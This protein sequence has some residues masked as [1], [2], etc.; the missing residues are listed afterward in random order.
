MTYIDLVN[1]VLRRLREDTVTTVN[2]TDYSLMVGDFINDAKR[3]CEDATDWSA[4]RKTLEV[5]TEDG[6]FSYVL[7]G[8]QNRG[9]VLDVVNDTS[10]FFLE[11]RTA[12]E[13][14]RKFLID[15]PEKNSPRYYSFNGVTDDD[16]GDTQVDLFPI[17]DKQYYINFNMII[18]QADLSADTDRLKIPAQ[19]VIHMALAML[20]RERGETGGT[21]TAEYFN[22]AQRYL[23]DAI[24][25]D[26]A[27][28][29]EEMIWYS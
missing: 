7:T 28:H 5:R 24:A 10:N 1:N 4:L 14:N 23:S 17:P 16:E 8:S 29:P 22:I 11:Y 25:F 2:Q 21:S 3:M 15:N 26:A 12:H 9:K 18:K 6:T 27:K 13:F 20:A 19:P